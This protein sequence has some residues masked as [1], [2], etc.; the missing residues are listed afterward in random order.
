MFDI[1]LAQLCS[2]IRVARSALWGMA[3][4]RIGLQGFAKVEHQV[5]QKTDVNDGVITSQAI[6][7]MAITA[8]FHESTQPIARL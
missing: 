2:R 1:M 5:E 6:D 8:A 4:L 7:A 3:E